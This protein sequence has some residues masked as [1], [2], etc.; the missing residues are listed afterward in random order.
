MGLQ[1]NGC[2]VQEQMLV[3][4]WLLEEGFHLHTGNLMEAPSDVRLS[5]V[6]PWDE[7]SGAGLGLGFCWGIIRGLA[8]L[9]QKLGHSTF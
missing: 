8:D 9:F 1:N 4:S 6:R 3:L 7:C 2:G 5:D